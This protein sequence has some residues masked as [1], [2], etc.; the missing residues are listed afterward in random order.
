MLIVHHSIEASDSN[1]GEI[2]DQMVQDACH[3]HWWQWSSRVPDIT[4]QH[5]EAAEFNMTER[6]EFE[7]HSYQFFERDHPFVNLL[8]VAQ[9]YHTMGNTENQAEVV[10]WFTSQHSYD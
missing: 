6:F 4:I 9:S 7:D 10:G 5:R 8:S 1:E 2:R 3:Q